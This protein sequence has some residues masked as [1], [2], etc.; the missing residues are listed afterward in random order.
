MADNVSISVQQRTTFGKKNKA[1]RRSGQVPVHVYGQGSDP[2]SLQVGVGELRT[3]LREAGA[4]T[5]VTVK[6]DG[7]EEAVTLVRDIATHPVSGDLLHVDFMRVN[8]AEEVEAVV[9]LR[10]INDEN[11]PGTQGGAG[12]VTQAIYEITVRALPFDIPSE[13]EVDCMVLVDLEAHIDVGDLK[14][15]S[16]VTVETDPETRIAWVQPPRVVEE[17]VPV[18]EGEEGEE[19][20]AGESAEGEGDGDSGGDSDSDDE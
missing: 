12:V 4:T 5:P 16:G 6:V 15:P 20:E 9:P 18:A 8:V 7:G 2:L 17:E 19:G 3:A 11:A 1:L 14:L 13:V 10:L